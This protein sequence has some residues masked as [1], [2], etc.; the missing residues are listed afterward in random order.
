MG[1]SVCA[2]MM[3]ICVFCETIALKMVLLAFK[4]TVSI[5]VKFVCRTVAN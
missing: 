2:K 4:T 3:N 1:T 5:L